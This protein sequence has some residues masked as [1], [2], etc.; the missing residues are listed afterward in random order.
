[1]TQFRHTVTSEDDGM[2][3][4]Q[5]TRQYFDFSARLRNRI[6]RQKLTMKNGN[7]RRAGTKSAKVM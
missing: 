2:E 7:P 1:M 6:K 3:V 4:R 5:I